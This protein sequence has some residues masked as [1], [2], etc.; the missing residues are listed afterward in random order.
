[1]DPDYPEDPGARPTYRAD[2]HDSLIERAGIEFVAA[3]APRL[4]CAKEPCLLEIRK[5]LLGQPPQL[6]GTRRAF[7]QFGQQCA[8]APQI[9]FGRH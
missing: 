1:M 9:L 7:A 4:Q 3:I 2:L 6:L 8:S 5:G